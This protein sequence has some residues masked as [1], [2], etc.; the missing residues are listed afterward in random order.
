M[1]ALYLRSSFWMIVSYN[2]LCECRA[3]AEGNNAFVR[4][5]VTVPFDA[6]LT[7]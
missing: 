1:P 6:R 2:H 3:V 4:D 7:A 5:L